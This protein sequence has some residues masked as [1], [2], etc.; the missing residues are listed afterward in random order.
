MGFL[1]V[2]ALS[3]MCLFA[4]VT[5]QATVVMDLFQASRRPF[6]IAANTIVIHL[7]GDV[8]SPIVLGA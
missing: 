6:A 7:L 5:G 2:Y 3:K 4:I 8:P 1:S